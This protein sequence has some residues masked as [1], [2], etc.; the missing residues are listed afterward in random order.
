MREVVSGDLNGSNVGRWTFA[1]E[2]THINRRERIQAVGGNPFNVRY[3]LGTQIPCIPL[4]II[5]VLSRLFE[6]GLIK[7]QQLAYR[8]AALVELPISRRPEIGT[9]L[10]SW[11]PR[12][13]VNL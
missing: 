7:W 11:K 5:D 9:Q 1:N 2:P 12:I 6:S 13:P 3:Y 8:L 10:R 4:E